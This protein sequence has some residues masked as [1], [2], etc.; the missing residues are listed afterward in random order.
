MNMRVHRF[1]NNDINQA[2]C[3]KLKVRMEKMCG[4]LRPSVSEKSFLQSARS[5]L[6]CIFPEF[7]CCGHRYAFFFRLAYKE[8]ILRQ[9][10][11]YLIFTVLGRNPSA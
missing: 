2:G 8:I 10:S 4:G 3:V 6:R 11:I 1:A 5:T 7:G 9:Y